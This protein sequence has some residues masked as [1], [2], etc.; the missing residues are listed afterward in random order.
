MRTRGSARV[1]EALRKEVAAQGLS[2]D[3]Q[4]TA[5]GSIGLCERGPNMIVY[6][7]GIW[8]SSVTPQ[9][10]P[11]IVRTHFQAGRV[12]ERL[13]NKDAVA[14]K[15]EICTN[16][17]KMLAAQR[18]R[19]AAGVLPDDLNSTLRGFQ[20]SR[21]ILTAV[22]LDLFA[23]VGN[24]ARADEVS[25]RIGSDPRA[26]EMLMNALVAMGLLDKQDAIFRNTPL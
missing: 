18:A 3:V 6:P 2:K 16:R 20:E 17:D 15:S 4:I 25:A 11:E 1:I 14:L 5:C 13:A 22:E 12:V 8:Y 23:A 24:G 21:V 19:E 26:T 10:V 9:D 7:E